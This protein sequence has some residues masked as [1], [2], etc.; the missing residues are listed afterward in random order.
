MKRYSKTLPM[1]LAL[2]RAN[3]FKAHLS[4]LTP[5]SR[6]QQRPDESTYV[7]AE[8]TKISS[9]FIRYGLV[10]PAL[11]AASV[12]QAD[13]RLEFVAT[14][15]NQPALTAINT[16]ITRNGQ[17]VYKDNRHSFNTTIACG[18]LH[19]EIKRGNLTRIRD[20]TTTDGSTSLV[21]VEMGE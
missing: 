2:R 18:S 21:V 20:I 4:Y 7:Y 17:Y 19:I 12:S 6:I 16:T 8:S 1:R 5:A 11:L 3:M 15:D 13:C 14:I 9:S 10:A